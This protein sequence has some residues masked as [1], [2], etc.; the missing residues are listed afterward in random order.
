MDAK[1]PTEVFVLALLLG[2]AYYTL[3]VLLANDTAK[4]IIMNTLIVTVYIITPPAVMSLLFGGYVLQYIKGAA[5]TNNNTINS[6]FDLTSLVSYFFRF[7]LQILRYLLICAKL[8]AMVLFS[9]DMFK[10]MAQESIYMLEHNLLDIGFLSYMFLSMN[11]SLDNG[12][13]YL[14]EMAELFLI[15]YAQIGALCIIIY[16][17]L[18]ALYSYA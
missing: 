8:F 16:W 18:K 5:S 12:M 7:A 15:F 9:G 11:I 6:F 3:T 4:L 2:L 17:L 1:I 13:H 14:L 10:C